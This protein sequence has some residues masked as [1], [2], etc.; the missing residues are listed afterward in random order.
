[1]YAIFAV[2][3][4]TLL[5]GMLTVVLNR[6]QLLLI[7]RKI[8]F[9][10]CAAQTRANSAKKNNFINVRASVKGAFFAACLY[11]WLDYLT[12]KEI[13]AKIHIRENHGEVAERLKA[14]VLKTVDPKGSV[15][16]NPTLSVAFANRSQDSCKIN[17]R[18]L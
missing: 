5:K 3:F 12:S 13:F 9:A 18:F 16:S 11:L 1:M 6:V 10:R 4:M 17:C 2:M 7:F 14:A 15:G 8:G